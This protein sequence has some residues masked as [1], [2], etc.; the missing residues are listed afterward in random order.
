MVVILV[1]G[2]EQRG[3]A[4]RAVS[5]RFGDHA[6]GRGRAAVV[7]WLVAIGQDAGID[8]GRIVAEG[9]IGVGRTDGGV[10]VGQRIEVARP[11]VVAGEG[12]D[13]GCARPVQL[14]PDHIPAAAVDKGVL[15]GAHHQPPRIASQPG[16]QCGDIAAIAGGAE[17]RLL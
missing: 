14:R 5:H 9:E 13:A 2:S 6:E 1:G 3:I 11:L 17:E 15:E 8:N 10:E 16:D 7:V 4:Q 12:G